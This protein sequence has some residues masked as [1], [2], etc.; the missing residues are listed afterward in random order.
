MQNLTKDTFAVFIQQEKVLV[1]FWAVW[2]GPCMMQGEVLT[3]LAKED[4]A[5]AAKIG[6]INVDEERDLAISYDVMSIP[7]LIL[8]SKGQE[9]KRFVG[10]QDSKTIRDA[11]K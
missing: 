3:E 1:D 6:K 5:L 8:F 7:T 9:V 10:L 11:L 2:C 4:A